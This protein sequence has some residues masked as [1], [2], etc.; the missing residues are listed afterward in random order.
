MTAH[1]YRTSKLSNK[2]KTC[3]NQEM[4]K[5]VQNAEDFNQE[6]DFPGSVVQYRKHMSN[7]ECRTEGIYN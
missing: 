7:M 5:E 2:K 3:W 1:N 6:I 4:T